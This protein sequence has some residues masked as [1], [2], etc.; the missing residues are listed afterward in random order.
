MS[1]KAVFI[2]LVEY[3]DYSDLSVFVCDLK[4][5]L[6]FYN[7]HVKKMKQCTSVGVE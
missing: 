2:K 5:N 7:V 1:I 3:T 6:Y 4:T